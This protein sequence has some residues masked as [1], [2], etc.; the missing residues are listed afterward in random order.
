MPGKGA[1]A[2]R[3]IGLAALIALSA[4]CRPFGT[5][6]LKGDPAWAAALACPSG[7]AA[8]RKSGIP[9]PAVILLESD[10]WAMVIGSDSPAFALY[11]DGRAIYRTRSGY[12]SVKLEPGDL[13]K[14]MDSLEPGSLAGLSGGYT[15]TESTDQ[16]RTWLFVYAGKQPAFVTVY[17]SLDDE[18][19]RAKLPPQIVAF[20]DKLRSFRDARASKWLPETIEVMV[21]PYEN[22]P[23]PSIVWPKRWPGLD[24]PTTRKRREGI[25]LYVPSYD[26]EPLK[27][28]LATRRPTGAVEI[29]GK[30]W[31]ASYRLPFPHEQL[32][33]ALDDC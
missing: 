23:E 22:A 3:A 6:V 30:K 20:R 12:V 18:E 28:F 32:W 15:A 26:F 4:S 31:A 19:V 17:G 9:A 11:E 24:A 33:M 10:P 1:T 25:S 21:W 7:L 16:P 13:H 8:A 5:Q 2:L 29:G 27:S 14:F